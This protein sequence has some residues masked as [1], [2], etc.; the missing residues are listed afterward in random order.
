MVFQQH[1]VLQANLDL[2]MDM[3]C[4][5]MGTDSWK[6]EDCEKFFKENMVIVCTAEILRGWL[7]HGF[8]AMD[9]IN[10]LVFDEAHHAKKDHPYAR[11][12]LDFYAESKK[13]GVTLL[14]KIFGMTASPVEAK[15]DVKKAASELEAMLHC[16]IATPKDKS[17]LQ[18]Y[19][20]TSQQEHVVA[21]P[22]L[23]SRFTTELYDKIH[24]KLKSNL[25]F[26][27]PLLYAH[28]A[29]KELGGWCAD[30]LWSFCLGEDECQKL[31]A[32]TES[33]H[34]AVKT[35]EPL[36][37]LEEQKSQLE[38]ARSIVKSHIF[39]SPC[40]NPALD[41]SPNLSSKVVLLIRY[42]RERFERPTD[43][44]CIVF[45]RQRYTARLLTMLFSEPT[46][47]TPYLKAGSL[48]C[49]QSHGP[50]A[51]RYMGFTYC[52]RLALN[53]AMLLS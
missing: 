10:L 39:H 34:H 18:G 25:V 12:I 17:S 8:I 30:R 41:T 35:L 49:Y 38:D 5:Q 4:G 50:F 15:T 51:C 37:I 23:G 27:K 29:S 1:A 2:P 13:N 20:V 53:G 11:I 44:K 45:V 33:R 42:L 32:K 6:R 26:R 7:H 48:V 19:K 21:Y 14:P 3:C 46:I 22:A 43:D 31:L 16:E 47:R 28:N 52:N 24:E 36:A 9:Q 40:Y